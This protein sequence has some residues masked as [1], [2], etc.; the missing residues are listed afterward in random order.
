MKICTVSLTPKAIE[1]FDDFIGLIDVPTFR[2]NLRNVFLTY[3]AN[4][5]DEPNESMERLIEDMRFAFDLLD[6]LE[7]EALSN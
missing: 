6:R 2:R 1:A 4:E 3:L 7:D 5:C